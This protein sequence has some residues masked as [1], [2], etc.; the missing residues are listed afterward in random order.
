MG[1]KFGF[2]ACQSEN[3][4]SKVNSKVYGEEPK[5]TQKWPEEPSG[6]ILMSGL[7]KIVNKIMNKKGFYFSV[8]LSPA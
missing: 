4:K 6:I 2:W 5:W 7:V 3:N 1:Q 8:H